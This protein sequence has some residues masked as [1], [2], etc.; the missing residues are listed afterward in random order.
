MTATPARFDLLGEG[1][2]ARLLSFPFFGLTGP[3][4]MLRHAVHAY[5]VD[6]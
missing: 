2:V 1:V 4:I 3:V 6:R 5:R